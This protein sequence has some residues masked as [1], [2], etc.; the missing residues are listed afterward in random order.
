MKCYKSVQNVESNGN[1]EMMYS[2]AELKA[3]ARESEHRR[4]DQPNTPGDGRVRRGLFVFISF[5]P[6]ISKLMVDIL[7]G[8]NTQMYYLNGTIDY[9][10]IVTRLGRRSLSPLSRPTGRKSL[11][12]REAGHCIPYGHQRGCWCCCCVTGDY[13]LIYNW[14][15]VLW[16]LQSVEAKSHK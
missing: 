4:G 1:I 13:E 16:L 3:Q 6:L 14:V 8:G 10:E 5:S 11:W 2:S 15:L 12:R 7:M 9:N